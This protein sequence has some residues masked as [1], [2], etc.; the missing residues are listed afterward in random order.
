MKKKIISFFKKNP[1]REF[2]SKDVAKKL[3]INSDHEYSS[4]KSVLYDLYQ[5]KFLTKNGKKY[6]LNNLPETNK[7][8]GI[9]Q[10]VK[11]L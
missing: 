9:L 2:K 8:T 3:N 1:G 7:V 10:I 5:E 6:K 4:L 11:D